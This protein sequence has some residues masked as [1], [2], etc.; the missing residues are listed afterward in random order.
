ML[1]FLLGGDLECRPRVGWGFEVPAGE[2]AELAAEWAPVAQL[3]VAAQSFLLGD[4]PSNDMFDVPH[5]TQRRPLPPQAV[6][7]TRGGTTAAAA[8]RVVALGCFLVKEL[9]DLPTVR[10]TLAAFVRL[11]RVG[12]PAIRDHCFDI[13]VFGPPERTEVQAFFTRWRDCPRRW[14]RPEPV[15]VD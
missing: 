3:G 7:R 11:G 13:A 12:A 8:T 15:L 5:R 1:E 9:T 2:L 10:P 14:V 6:K 4:F